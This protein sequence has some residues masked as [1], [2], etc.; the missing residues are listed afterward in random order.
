M[1]DHLARQLAAR[2]AERARIARHERRRPLG[3]GPPALAV[4][5]RAEERV[6]VEPPRLGGDELPEGARAMRVLAPLDLVEAVE[7][8]PERDLLQPPDLAVLDTRRRADRRQT[9]PVGRGQHRRLAA[10]RRE[11]EHVRHADENRI[12]GERAGRVVRR[13]LAGGHLVERQQ[14]HEQTARPPPATP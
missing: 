12:D 1:N 8:R 11:F 14:L 10:E 3:P 13:L 4:A 7:R 6:V 9:V 5:Q 2:V